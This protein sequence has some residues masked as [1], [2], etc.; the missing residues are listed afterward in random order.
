MWVLRLTPPRPTPWARARWS[1]YWRKVL[2]PRLD[3]NPYDP[4]AGTQGEHLLTLAGLDSSADTSGAVSGD[5]STSGDAALEPALD[6]TAPTFLPA[7]DVGTLPPAT[8]ASLPIAGPETPLGAPFGD[9]DHLMAVHQE[10]E[11]WMSQD[12][13]RLEQELMN[14][15]TSLAAVAVAK[16]RQAGEDNSGHVAARVGSLIYNVSENLWY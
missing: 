12:P 10:A 1:R 14:R 6:G 3:A 8:P 13:S 2:K 16:G 7:T 15:E 4:N 11:F 9:Y 5:A